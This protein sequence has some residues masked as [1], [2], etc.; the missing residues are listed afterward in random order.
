[1]IELYEKVM[2]RCVRQGDCLV[3]TGGTAKGYGRVYVNHGYRQV[4]AHRV[5]FEHT[6]GT[7]EKGVFVDHTCFNRLCC[8]I[9]HLRAVTNKENLENRRTK[10]GANKSSGLRGVS[11][12]KASG[13]WQV[14]VRHNYKIHCGGFYATIDDAS[15]AAVA[16]RNKLFTHNNEDREHL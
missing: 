5:V 14:S 11:F 2:T 1:M 3:W 15:N 12:H 9:S 6:H 16:L 7:L 10:S 4:Q 8:E 13:K